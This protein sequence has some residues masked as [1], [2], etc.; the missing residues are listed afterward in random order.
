MMNCRKPID[1]ICLCDAGG[2]IRP[3]RIRMEDE[4][5]EYIRVDIE[6]ILDTRISSFPGAESVAYLCRVTIQGHPRILEIKYSV[7]S[8]SWSLLW[9]LGK[10]WV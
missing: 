4:T 5:M 3:L 1:V 9:R 7:P 10:N 2:S 6:E 8:H